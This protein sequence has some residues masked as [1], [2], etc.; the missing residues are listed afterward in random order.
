MGMLP[1][2]I[3][4]AAQK[5]QKEEASAARA[6]S[7]RQRREAEEA[8][9]KSSRSGYR[10]VNPEKLTHLKV[11]EISNT[12]VREFLEGFFKYAQIKNEEKI[13]SMQETIKEK[14]SELEVLKQQDEVMTQKQKAAAEVLKECINKVKNKHLLE[15][16]VSYFGANTPSGKIMDKLQQNSILRQIENINVGSLKLNMYFDFEA[17]HGVPL[18]QSNFYKKL[19]EYKESYYEDIARLEGNLSELQKQLKKTIWLPKRKELKN[20]IENL[21]SEISTERTR[22][23]QFEDKIDAFF[24]FYDIVYSLDKKELA[25]IEDAISD[26]MSGRRSKLSNDLYSTKY[27]INDL[28]SKIESSKKPDYKSLVESYVLDH[29]EYTVDILD[30]IEKGIKVAEKE[31]IEKETGFCLTRVTAIDGKIETDKMCQL[32]KNVKSAVIDRDRERE[33]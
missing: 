11:E 27:S 12:Q 13:A 18:K 33:E 14:E 3:L 29:P 8:K 5:R 16:R 26:G 7:A 9:L 28:T 31:S 15:Y 21:S 23:T 22:S 19:T 30:E 20:S 32:V 1:F 10:Y 4:A 2:L 6:R 25:V 24:E 17:V